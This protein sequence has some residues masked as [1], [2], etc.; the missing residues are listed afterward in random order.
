[1]IDIIHGITL[2]ID[3]VAELAK[4]TLYIAGTWMCVKWIRIN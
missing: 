4:L 1:M 3:L 2:A